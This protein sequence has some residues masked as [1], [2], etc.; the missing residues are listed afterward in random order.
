MVYLQRSFKLDL[1]PAQSYLTLT[2]GLMG[3]VSYQM[4]RL[5]VGAEAQLD[6]LLLKVDNKN[7]SSGFGELLFGAGWRF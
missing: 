1:V 5:T 3:G 7:R 6:F 2:P 4:G